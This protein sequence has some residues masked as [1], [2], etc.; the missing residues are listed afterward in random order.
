MLP[1]VGIVGGLGYLV[2]QVLLGPIVPL[3]TT[4][5]YRDARD[6]GER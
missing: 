6:A 1:A 3:L 4:I 2:V 5:L